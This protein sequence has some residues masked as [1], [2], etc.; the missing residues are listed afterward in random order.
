MPI[1]AKQCSLGEQSIFDLWQ[2]QQVTTFR[3]IQCPFL[4]SN[5]INR[6][7]S[8]WDAVSNM[9]YRDYDQGVFGNPN[10]EGGNRIMKVITFLQKL[11]AGRANWAHPELM[12]IAEEK[13][14]R[15]RKFTGPD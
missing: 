10:H 12:M 9:I 8:A 13:Y 6:W 15:K 3:A 2:N 11:N 7:D 4:E 1:V 14:L 5:F